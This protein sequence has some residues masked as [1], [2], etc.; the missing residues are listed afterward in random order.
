M[1][2]THTEA[3]IHSKTTSKCQTRNNYKTLK[4]L[5]WQKW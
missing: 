3:W 1:I 4:A 5:A 2:Q